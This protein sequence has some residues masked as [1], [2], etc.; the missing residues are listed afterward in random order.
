MRHKENLEI[1][2]NKYNILLELLQIY[3]GKKEN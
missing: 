3:G 2:H 1:V